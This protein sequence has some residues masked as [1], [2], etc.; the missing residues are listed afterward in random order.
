MP[1]KRTQEQNGSRWV[2]VFDL[3]NV[4]RP[5]NIYIDRTYILTLGGLKKII[6]KFLYKHTL[7]RFCILIFALQLTL[8]NLVYGKSGICMLS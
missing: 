2:R 3:G 4:K 7:I 6:L 5:E 8:N 1:A